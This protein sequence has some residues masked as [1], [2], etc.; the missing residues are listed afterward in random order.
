MAKSMKKSKIEGARLTGERALFMSCELYVNDSIFCDGESPLKES[1]NIEVQN[2][3]FDWKYPLWYCH[4]IKSES[5]VFTVNARA[6]IWYTNDIQLINVQ[7]DAPKCLRRCNN[8]RLINA[9]F[10][11]ALETLWQC[12]SI[13][14]KNVRVKGDYFAMNCSDI[15][16]DGLEIN[17]GYSFDGAKNVH[18]KNSKLISKDSFWN[19]ENVTVENSFISGEYIGWNAKN[20]TFINCTIESLQGFCY[21][22]GLVMR[23]CRLQNTD[24][25]FEY[26][27][28]DAELIGRAES[29]KNP[30]GGKIK[31]DEV[32][33]L[34]IEPD[35]IDP[36][37]TEI[38]I[39]GKRHEI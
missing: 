14:G 27:T 25:A 24:L 7:I 4:D 6:G 1:R 29:I 22:D 18:I 37:K 32:G 38:I 36:S 34:I 19:S 2:S 9:E 15:S 26:S 33:E 20:L 35:K 8:V 39:G 10:T 3:T 13:Y 12:Q 30:L 5:C 11:N 23:N 31:I 17:G 28:V 21:I 16:F